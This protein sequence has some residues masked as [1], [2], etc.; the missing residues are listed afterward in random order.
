MGRGTDAAI[1]AGSILFLGLDFAG[2]AILLGGRLAFFQYQKQ[3]I[4]NMCQSNIS[5]T[6]PQVWL[7]CNTAVENRMPPSC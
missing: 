7:E 1:Q 2:F 4:N 3:S 5:H 6:S